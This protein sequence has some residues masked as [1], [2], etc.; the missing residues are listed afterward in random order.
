MSDKSELTGYIVN[1][2]HWDREWRYSMWQTRFM[3]VEVMD[4]LIENLE[5]GKYKSFLMDGQ[6]SPIM[7]YLEIRPEKKEQLQKLIS[8]GKIE[9]GPWYTLPDEF[10]I[11]GEAMVRNLL[12][13]DRLAK[14]LGGGLKIG[15]T[16]F[17]WGQT[18]QLPQLYKE[19]GMDVAFIGKR[20]NNERAPQSEFLWRGPDGSELLASRF[21]DCGRQNFYFHIHLTSLFG[22]DH[23]S[24][25]WCYHWDQDGIIYHRSDKDFY[26]QDMSRLDAPEKW[27]P[28]MI[29][30]ERIEKV[31]ATT[32]ES[33]IDEHRIMMNGCDYAGSQKLLPEMIEKLKGIDKNRSRVWKQASLSEFVKVMREKI[34]LGTIASVEGELRDGPA[35][36]MTGNALMTRN[37]LKFLNKKAQNHLIRFAEPLSVMAS[38]RGAE[39]PEKM[40]ELAWKNLLDSHPHDSINGVTQDV[41]ADDVKVRLKQSIELSEAIGDNALRYLS[42]NIEMNHFDKNDVVLAVFNPLPY[43]REEMVETWINVPVEYSHNEILVPISEGIQIFDSK[44]NPVN[45]QWVSVEDHVASV[46]EVHT[47][48]FPFYNKR[49]RVIFDAGIIPAGGYKLFRLGRKDESRKDAQYADLW[50]R[51]GDIL[52]SPDI[53]ENEYLI[54]KFNSNGTFDLADKEHNHTFYNLNYYEDAAEHGDYWTNKRAMEV[55]TYSSLCCQSRIWTQESG[56]LRATIV[57]E[58]TVPLPAAS[59]VDWQRRGDQLID[60]VLRT[61]VTLKAGSR[62]VDVQ[63]EFE[64]RHKDHTLRVML[65]T[66]LEKAE[67]AYVGGHFNVQKRSIYPQGPQKGSY[68]VDMARLPHDKFVDVSDGDNGFAV[69]NDCL[70]EY[71]VSNTPQRVLALTLLR[72]V[73]NALCTELRSWTQFN[74]QD[75]GQCLGKHTVHYALRPHKGDWSQADI[76]LHA[77]LFNSAVYPVQTRRH[78]GFLQSHQTSFIQIKDSAIRFSALKQCH[79]RDNYILRLYNPTN[80]ARETEIEFS[81]KLANIWLCNL[82]ED[83]LSEIKSVSNTLK[84]VFEPK[85][86]RTIEFQV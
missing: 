78:K 60:M 5:T 56:P 73:R 33:V 48:T 23:F 34:D 59:T 57:S 1:H 71:E 45:T 20:V 51:T 65:P 82:N 67:Y 31:W 16:S 2:T 35:A 8:S 36:Y 41:T 62:Q 39:F 29:T 38:M 42:K 14:E 77:D 27:H 84:I 46:Q 22:I 75:G 72:A 64:N 13:G 55:Q 43:E 44:D 17:G 86:I 12:W 11:D 74:N 58:V 4:E 24:P 53:M 50:S 21:G 7:D 19:F 30:P 18:A 85:K 28:E 76:P 32:N 54:V 49:H 79:D 61:Y 52:K 66:G 80:M 3:L 6:V 81:S 40:I 68:W 69:L 9:I 47:R 37:Y 15:Y 83:R 26:E 70:V 25:S 10:P 63:V